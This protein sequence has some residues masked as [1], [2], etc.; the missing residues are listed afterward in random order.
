MGIEIL[1]LFRCSAQAQRTRVKGGGMG[2]ALL[3]SSAQE[4]NAEAGDSFEAFRRA[5]IP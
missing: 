2:A 3:D 1:D 4:R 5:P